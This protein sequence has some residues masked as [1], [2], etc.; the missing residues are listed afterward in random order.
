V[1]KVLNNYEKKLVGNAEAFLKSNTDSLA[2]RRVLLLNVSKEISSALNVI[3]NLNSKVVALGETDE[4]YDL[5]FY[6]RIKYI[7]ASLSEVRFPHSLFDGVALFMN[8]SK[9]LPSE[10]FAELARISKPNARLYL[11]LLSE[12]A[13]EAKEDYIKLLGDSFELTND[14]G[15]VLVFYN[16][17]A[18]SRRSVNTIYVYHPNLEGDGITEYA[19]HL[20]YRLRKRGLN[21]VEGLP[22][23]EDEDDFI[24]VE[25]EEELSLRNKIK[26]LEELPRNSY[27][28]VHSKTLHK[29]RG[30]LTYLYHAVP[31]HYGLD[32]S[33]IPWYYVPHIAYEIELPES[34]K[35][36]DY[37]SFGFWFRFKH[38]DRIRKLKGRKKLVM[39]FNYKMF[40]DN[41]IKDSCRKTLGR[42]LDVICSTPLISSKNFRR[43]IK[44]RYSLLR[45]F[46]VKV[47]IKDYI[48]HDELIRELSECKAFIF[49]HDTDDPSSGS[50]RLAAALGVPVYAKDNMRAKEAQVIRY[51][52]LDEV[53]RLPK[54][55]VNIDDGLDYILSLIEY[56]A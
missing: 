18:E 32:F 49:F 6:W 7:K 23:E 33:G 39:S 44:L 45:P 13:L 24:L 34:K 53:D 11:F 10:A 29:L 3:G 14:E 27:V 1:G 25:F 50:M 38:F 19:R 17:K 20:I 30:D 15:S 54:D 4:V 36:Y 40:D 22:Q 37:C 41:F 55:K 51:R 9:R 42:P 56:K 21:V 28:E 26:K 31:S 8:S 5:P 35:T 12:D 2:N 47:V 46:N 52:S 16:R 43:L 48:P